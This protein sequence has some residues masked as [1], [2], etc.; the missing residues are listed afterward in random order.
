MLHGTLPSTAAVA[1]RYDPSWSRETDD[2]DDDGGQ[3][4]HVVT[5]SYP[6]EAN[7]GVKARICASRKVP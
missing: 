3:S 2:D 5:S 4:G 7:S 6:M 1:G